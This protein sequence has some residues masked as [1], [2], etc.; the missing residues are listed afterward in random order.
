MVLLFIADKV[1]WCNFCIIFFPTPC[2][3]YRKLRALNT[4]CAFYIY[5]KKK[6]KAKAIVA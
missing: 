4:S 2:T 3:K 5:L 1:Q 6:K